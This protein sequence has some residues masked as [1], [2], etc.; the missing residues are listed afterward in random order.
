MLLKLLQTRDL[1]PEISFLG[2]VYKNLTWGRLG[3]AV[4]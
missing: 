2:S 3:G 4:G 1:L